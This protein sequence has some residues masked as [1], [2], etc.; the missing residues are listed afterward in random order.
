[1]VWSSS[2]Y[3]YAERLVVFVKA[4][5]RLSLNIILNLV[6]SEHGILGLIGLV[7]TVSKRFVAN[8]FQL[9]KYSRRCQGIDTQK[10][11]GEA[12]PCNDV[13]SPS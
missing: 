5:D 12:T 11:C 9:Y 4:C 6:K 2:D 7:L 8:N 3:C 13:Y 10:G 1:M